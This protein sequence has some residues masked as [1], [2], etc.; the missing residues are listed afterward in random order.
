MKNNSTKIRFRYNPNTSIPKRDWL[1]ME[2]QDKIEAILEY[3]KKHK[4]NLWNKEF[5]L[6][7][8]IEIENQIAKN[9]RPVNNA[10]RRLKRSGMRR[11][12]AIHAIGCIFI[13]NVEILNEEKSIKYRRT[14]YYKEIDLLTIKSF[15][16]RNQ[17]TSRCS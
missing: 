11:H 7:L 3:H 12:D 13:E 15:F 14:K 5:H 16:K 10:L 17:I 1:S 6:N 8:H 4:T 9:I 2:E